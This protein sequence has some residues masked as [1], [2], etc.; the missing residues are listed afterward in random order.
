MKK[1][2]RKT[3]ELHCFL[4]ETYYS[5]LKRHFATPREDVDSFLP[6]LI[7][8]TTLKYRNGE[9]ATQAL[10]A[11]YNISKFDPNKIG[12]QLKPVLLS[13]T[14]EKKVNLQNQFAILYY[15][16]I[17]LN[18]CLANY[19][20]LVKKYYPELIRGLSSENKRARLEVAN[21]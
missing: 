21:V 6:F 19:P 14:S 17:C 13:A 3:H 10:A 1:G 4:S 7:T 15:Y 9:S 16:K 12:V 5:C 2:D 18:I 8:G 11:I 20:A